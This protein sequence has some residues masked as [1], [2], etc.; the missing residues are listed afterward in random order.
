VNFCRCQLKCRANERAK[1]T[2]E[3]LR[4]R[5]ADF[6]IPMYP[7]TPAER[8][9]FTMLAKDLNVYLLVSISCWFFASCVL[10]SLIEF[11]VHRFLMHRR[12]LPHCVYQCIPGFT[13]VFQNH[14][15]LHHGRYYKVFNHE[16]DPLGRRTSIRLDLWIALVGGG[17]VWALTFPLDRVVGPVFA[18]V[19]F[20]H[21][22]AWNCIHKEM[23]NPKRPWFARTRLYKFLAH[24]HWMHHKYPGKNFNVVLPGADFLFGKYCKPSET[25][26][27]QMR[28]IGI[29]EMRG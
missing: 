7:Q 19:L 28:A 9:F 25:D 21:H 20:L 17:L 22:L 15:V 4:G 29:W 18:S 5:T 1:R 27:A 2:C 12:S 6:L 11:F 14:A 26:I 3:K 16:D 10:M 13:T 23:H 24:Y 8:E